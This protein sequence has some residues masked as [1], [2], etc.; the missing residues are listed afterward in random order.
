[1]SWPHHWA[2]FQKVTFPS[3]PKSV[4]A[5]GSGTC[6]QGPERQDQHGRTQL[7]QG[8]GKCES[9]GQQLCQPGHLLTPSRDLLTRDLFRET[10]EDMKQ[11]PQSNENLTRFFGTLRHLKSCIC[12]PLLSFLCLLLSPSPFPGFLDKVFHTQ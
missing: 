1:M 11:L 3:L 8:N 9:W 10:P 7:P 2:C 5:V 12:Q 4:A 6:I